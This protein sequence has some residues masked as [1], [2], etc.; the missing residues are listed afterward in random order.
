MK[1]T[2]DQ[3]VQIFCAA[4]QACIAKTSG[5]DGAAY[6]ARLF[7]AS[8]IKE[9]EEHSFEYKGDMDYTPIKAL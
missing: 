8:A 7:T 9:I 2:D 1:L 4:L 5:Y 6:Q 3:K